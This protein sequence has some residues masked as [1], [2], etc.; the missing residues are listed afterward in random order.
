MMKTLCVALVAAV[1]GFGT[2]QILQAQGKPHAYV[3][4]NINVTNQ[5]KYDAWAGKLSQYDKAARR[6]VCHPRGNT[7][8]PVDGEPAKRAAVIE[9]ENMDK[10]KAWA[11]ATKA[12]RAEDRGATVNSWIVEGMQ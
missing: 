3:M 11:D 2:S 7:I 9:F 5:A 1:I 4:A 12:L 6:Q 8:A 10:A